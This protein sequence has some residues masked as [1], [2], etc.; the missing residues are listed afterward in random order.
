MLSYLKIDFSYC[1]LRKYVIALVPPHGTKKKN[2]FGGLGP[3]TIPFEATHTDTYI[4]HIREYPPP[5]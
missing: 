5:G 3:W 1:R 2:I 4:A